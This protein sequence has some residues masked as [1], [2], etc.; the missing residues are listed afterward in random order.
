MRYATGRN[1]GTEQV[2]EIDVTGMNPI[3]EFGFVDAVAEFTDKS[4]NIKGKVYV[5]VFAKDLLTGIPQAVLKAYDDGAYE[6]M[7]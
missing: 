5:S 2:L 3:D 1:Y 6:D 4:R 7:V